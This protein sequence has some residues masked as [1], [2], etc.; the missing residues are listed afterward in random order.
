[1]VDRFGI[2]PVVAALSSLDVAGIHSRL[3]WV[4]TIARSINDL[5]EGMSRGGISHRPLLFA[6][7]EI[8]G[9]DAVPNSVGTD[10]WVTAV[11]RTRTSDDVRNEDLLASFLFARAR[12]WRSRSAGR[13]FSISVQ[14]L[15][16][17]MASER[18]TEKAWSVAKLRLPHGSFWGNWDQCEKLRHAVV[19][20][21]I[22]RELPPIEFGTVVVNDNLWR[23][24]VDL[25]ADSFRGR[26]RRRH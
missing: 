6:L 7:A 20:S 11:E 21:F 22:D 9:P 25:A 2:D 23:S 15:H 13:L 19:A 16:E 4:Q 26:R 3:A 1:M 18:L 8:L 10:P 17:A 14:R 24:L 12:G 5:A